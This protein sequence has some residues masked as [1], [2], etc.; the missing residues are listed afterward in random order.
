[1]HGKGLRVV[2]CLLVFLRV[3]FFL[4]GGGGGVAGDSSFTGPMM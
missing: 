4:G 3:S 1:M 2:V